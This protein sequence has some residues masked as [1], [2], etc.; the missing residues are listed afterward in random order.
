[1]GIASVPGGRAAAPLLL[2]GRAEPAPDVSDAEHAMASSGI[3]QRR[4]W[5][6][7]VSKNILNRNA[8]RGEDSHPAFSAIMKRGCYFV[9]MRV[10]SSPTMLANGLKT[11]NELSDAP[12]QRMP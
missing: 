2:S 1:M 5:S 6:G 11:K 4:S 8:G 9:A 3:A 12:P 7:T 10:P